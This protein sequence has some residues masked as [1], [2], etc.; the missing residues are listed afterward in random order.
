[1][2]VYEAIVKALE[3]V[4]VDAA[5]GGPGENATGLMVA[6]KHCSKIRPVIV[7]HEQAVSC[8]TCGYAIYSTSLVSSTFDL[9]RASRTSHVL[10][11]RA[12]V[13]V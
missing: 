1:M 8:I 10:V 4:D 11:M 7:R 12:L 9:S 3:S 6:L 5:F 13:A 2:R